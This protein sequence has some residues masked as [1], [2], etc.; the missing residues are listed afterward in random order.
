MDK[1]KIKELSLDTLTSIKEA[2]SSTDDAL[3]G[4]TLAN[5]ASKI[6]LIGVEV[7]KPDWVSVEK[8]LPEYGEEVWVRSKKFPKLVYTSYRIKDVN[9][10]NGFDKN[11]FPLEFAVT[12]WRKIEK[13][14]E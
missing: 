11:D 7:N 3:L 5:I 13:L 4:L 8:G 10:L 14:E 2:M 9:G 12:H 6:A 1:K